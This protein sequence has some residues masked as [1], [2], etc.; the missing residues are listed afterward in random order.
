LGSPGGS[1]SNVIFRRAI[2]VVLFGLAC[3]SGAIA[4]G[5]VDLTRQLDSADD[6]LRRIEIIRALKTEVDAGNLR[7]G[8]VNGLIKRLMSSDIIKNPETMS[9]LSSTLASPIGRDETTVAIAGRMN[10]EPISPEIARRLF[11]MLTNYDAD[12]GLPLTTFRQLNRILP[13][14]KDARLRREMYE[15]I[16]ASNWAS[17]NRTE[18]L[19]T[20]AHFLAPEYPRSDRL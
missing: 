11:A 1:G 10:G 5:I 2:I 14:M 3:Q 19:P 9:L 13:D 6:N 7:V 16:A 15:Y 17:L 8:H 12:Y 4:A 18:Y 20:V